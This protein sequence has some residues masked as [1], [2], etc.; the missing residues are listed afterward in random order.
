M[1]RPVLSESKCQRNPFVELLETRQL[2]ANVT[3]GFTDSTFV[4]GLTRPT[5]VSFAPD[6]RIFV[7][8]Q[9]GKLRIVKNGTLLPTPAIKLAVSQAGERGLQS[10]AFDPDF[11]ALFR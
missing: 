8:E 10:V 2:L 4:S 5:A 6:G 7:S 9:G 1:P 3:P 11:A